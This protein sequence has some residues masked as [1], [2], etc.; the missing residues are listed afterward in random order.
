MNT[1]ELKGQW[2]TIKGQLKQKYASLTDDDLLFVEGKEDE[3]FGR[4][5]KRTGQGKEA[6]KKQ[7]EQFAKKL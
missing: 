7:I 3:L 6:L 1:L 4:L 2:H 5:E